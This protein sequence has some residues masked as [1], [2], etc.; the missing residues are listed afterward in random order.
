MERFSKNKRPLNPTHFF[1]KMEKQL[2]TRITKRAILM[3]RFDDDEERDFVKE[4]KQIGKYYNER[5]Y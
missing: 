5:Q 1:P 2:K 3:F 4:A